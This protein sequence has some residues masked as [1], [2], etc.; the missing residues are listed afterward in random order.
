[1]SALPEELSNALKDRGDPLFLP[2]LTNEYAAPG[3]VV[4]NRLVFSLLEK[5]RS[6]DERDIVKPCVSHG[7]GCLSYIIVWKCHLFHV[8]NLSAA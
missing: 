1:M 2:G 3:Q 7:F 4:C 5:K 8:I 6:R